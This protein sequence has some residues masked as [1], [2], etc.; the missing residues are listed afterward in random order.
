MFHWIQKS[1]DFHL[2][3]YEILQLSS[4]Y[5]LFDPMFNKKRIYW[6]TQKP[7]TTWIWTSKQMWNLSGEAKKKIMKNHELQGLIIYGKQRL[8]T[9]GKSPKHGL[10]TPWLA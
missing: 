4:C 3:R 10:G 9:L 2:S 8:D 7:N 5:Q 1:I 6:L